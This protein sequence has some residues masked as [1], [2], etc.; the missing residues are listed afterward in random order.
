[1]LS[2]VT[3]LVVLA[4][5]DLFRES[6]VTHDKSSQNTTYERAEKVGGQEMHQ[7]KALI[8]QH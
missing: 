1:M 3:T 7:V 8:S 2:N 4:D 6:K 5:S